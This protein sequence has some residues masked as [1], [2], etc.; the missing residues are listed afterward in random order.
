MRVTIRADHLLILVQI[1]LDLP[2]RRSSQPVVAPMFKEAVS[3][4]SRERRGYENTDRMD[5]LLILMHEVRCSDTLTKQ[6]VMALYGISEQ[7]ARALIRALTKK[8][9]RARLVTKKKKGIGIGLD[10][11]FGKATTHRDA[12]RDRRPNPYKYRL[13]QMEQSTARVH[14]YFAATCFVN[15]PAGKSA[16]EPMLLS[17]SD[18]DLTEPVQPGLCLDEYI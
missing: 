15:L 8:D 7:E 18:E 17:L 5:H 6:Q 12:L 9:P 14:R 3:K 16:P 11:L 13:D 2:Q 1:F 4:S 10:S